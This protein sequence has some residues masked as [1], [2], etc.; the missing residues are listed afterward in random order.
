MVLFSGIRKLLQ[1]CVVLTS[2]SPCRR[3]ILSN[4]DT[5]YCHGGVVSAWLHERFV[6]ARLGC[7]L[8]GGRWR[9]GLG[10]A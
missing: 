4:A 1:K 6:A 10:V 5:L 8:A 7:D 9:R 3:E 2:A